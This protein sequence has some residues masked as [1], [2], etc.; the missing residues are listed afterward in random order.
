[1]QSTIL[2]ISVV[3]TV[4]S[5][6]LS[7]L[8]CSNSSQSP[9]VDSTSYIL[10]L[11]NGNYWS[12]SLKCTNGKFGIVTDTV[13]ITMGA[14]YQIAG[15]HWFKFNPLDSK[16]ACANS[17]ARRLLSVGD[18]GEYNYTY[19]SNQANG[20]SLGYISDLNN[21]SS[22]LNNTVWKYPAKVGDF[23]SFTQKPGG[24]V[25]A[26]RVSS[27]NIKVSV[28][29]GTYTCYEYDI[30]STSDPNTVY[31]RCYMCPNVGLI[32]VH[33]ESDGDVAV[34]LSAHVR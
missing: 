4:C 28:P 14:E 25:T 34:L 24:R 23:Y 3:L 9:S 12:Y 15:V 27:T 31:T 20:Y 26:C 21:T 5:I 32:K 33:S 7:T 13:T 30:V 18:D 17:F 19:N 22:M 10:P 11:A 29:A 2:F 1:M 6:A 8:S 16:T